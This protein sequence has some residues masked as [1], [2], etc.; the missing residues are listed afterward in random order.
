ME[1][2]QSIY[3][4]VLSAIPLFS[5]QR[6]FVEDLA[7]C[8]TVKTVANCNTNANLIGNLPLIMQR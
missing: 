6:E 8:V 2:T 1:L 5:E 3:V 7:M 4:P